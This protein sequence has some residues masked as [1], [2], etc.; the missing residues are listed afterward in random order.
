MSNPFPD[1]LKD[2]V[3]DRDKVCFMYKLDRSHI[4]RTRF[5][6]MHGPGDRV[7][8]TLDHVKM[9]IALSIRKVHKPWTLVAM[10]G[11][12]NNR[13]PT[14]ETREAERAYLAKLYPEHW[15]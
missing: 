15:S 14:Q 1:G 12:E 7:R 6:V 4:C 2:E 3:L 10:C 8:L 13:P 9:R 5:G 11:Y